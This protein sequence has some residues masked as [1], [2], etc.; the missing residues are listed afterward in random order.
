MGEGHLHS[1]SIALKVQSVGMFVYWCQLIWD[2]EQFCQ[3]IV[4][5]DNCFS[6]YP[7]IEHEHLLSSLLQ[8]WNE[9]RHLGFLYWGLKTFNKTWLGS[10][11]QFCQGCLWEER[12]GM[13]LSYSCTTSLHCPQLL[14]NASYFRWKIFTLH[15]LQSVL[16]ST[17][18]YGNCFGF[19]CT[20]KVPWWPVTGLKYSWL[21]ANF[22]F[23]QARLCWIRRIVE[24]LKLHSKLYF[25]H[26]QCNL[27]RCASIS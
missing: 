17:S 2:K 27:F 22:N 19:D 24:S 3:F 21:T 12:R 10:L 6:K 13:K 15:K 14:G 20:V 1:I 9:L 5:R 4:I 23:T 11:E 25:R 16:I 26:R 18:K 8:V 7:N